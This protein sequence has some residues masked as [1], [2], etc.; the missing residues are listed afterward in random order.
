MFRTAVILSL[1]LTGQAVASVECDSAAARW[2]EL[3]PPAVEESIGEP[4]SVALQ[5]VGK[6]WNLAV[7]TYVGAAMTFD[8]WSKDDQKKLRLAETVV[9]LDTP[10][11]CWQPEVNSGT[12]EQQTQLA[13]F[14]E[15][16]PTDQRSAFRAKVEAIMKDGE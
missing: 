7:A 9:V 12:A 11:D 15:L 6:R 4:M 1:G 13:K 5:K 16:F 3:T 10:I 14:D 2:V 8:G